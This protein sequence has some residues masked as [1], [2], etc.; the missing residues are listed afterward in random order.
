[1][2]LEQRRHLEKTGRG[3]AFPAETQAPM[4]AQAAGHSH[5][6]GAVEDNGECSRALMP[7]RSA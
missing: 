7:A 3:N 1:M 6:I 2:E 5:F 4:A